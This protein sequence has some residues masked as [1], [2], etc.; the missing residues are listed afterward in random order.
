M[1]RRDEVLVGMFTTAAL[2]VA[3][4]GALWLARGGLSAGYP[5]YTRFAW[6]QG[7]K[8]GQPVWLSGA[9]VG[10]VDNIRFEPGGTLLVTY[11]IQD[12]YQVPKGTTAT[13]LPNGFFG[14]VAIGLTPD[15][16]NTE[17]FAPGDTVPVGAPQ[18]GIA[19]LTASADTITQGVNALLRGAKAE[20]VDSGGMA[21]MRRTAAAMNRLVVQFGQI[22][23]LQSKELQATLVTVRGKAAAVDSAQVD[24]AVSALRATAVNLSVATAELK[25]TADKLNSLLTKLDSGPGTAAKL[26]NDPALYGDVRAVLTRLDSLMT[27]FQKNPRKFI[28]LSIF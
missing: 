23:A 20:F 5:L 13:I 11:R 16:P 14:D 3:V 17:S 2:V 25:S 7:L 22:A 9:T 24:S 1:K 15:K 19:K 21:D 18:A 12:E 6:G 26:V 27:E 10:F 28:N 8:Q 4:L